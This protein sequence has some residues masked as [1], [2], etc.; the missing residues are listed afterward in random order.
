MVSKI[1]KCRICGNKNLISVIALGTQPQAGVFPKPNEKVDEGPLELM[2]CDTSDANS[3]GLVQ[4]N[5]SFQAT[6]L[7]GENYGYRSGLNRSMVN[8]LH[9]KVA[10]VQNF[11]TLKPGDIVVDIGSNDGTLLGAYSDTDNLRRIGID[12]TIEKFGGYY[13]DHIEKY[14]EFFTKAACE[15]ILG[16]QKAKVITSVSMF[17]DLESPFEFVSVIKEALADDGI[18]VFEQSYLPLMLERNSY[19]TICHEHLEYYHLRPILWM[20]NK[21]GLRIV[22]IEVNDINGGSIS[23]TATHKSSKHFPLSP[24]KELASLLQAEEKLGLDTL[25]PYKNFRDRVEK[26]R[27]DLRR[28]LKRLKSEGKRVFGYGAST[29]GNV[30][31]NYCGLE[32]SLIECIA[33]VNEDKV[34]RLTPGSQIPIIAEAEA[35]RQ[36]PDFFLVLPWHFRPFFVEKESAFLK[37]GGRFIFPLPKVEEV[38]P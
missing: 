28:E 25:A 6:L 34:G 37:K 14:P 35:R 15:R 8:H 11:S 21:A 9:K 13:K 33:E 12:P 27:D 4:L 24:P 2:K 23:L 19:D 10:Y 26:S 30:L 31:L 32:S 29:K 1:E 16:S 22:D 3:C 5:H 17:Y 18:W 38:G 20:L 7:Y 36:N